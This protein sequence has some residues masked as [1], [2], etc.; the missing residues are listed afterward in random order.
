MAVNFELPVELEASLR[1]E[2]GDLD[3]AAKEAALVELYRQHKLTHHELSQALGISRFE[4]EALLK[5]HGVNYEFS[6]EDI[7]RESDSLR[8]TTNS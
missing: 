1:R 3:H 2:L 7:R 8:N 6:L 4:A 5:I